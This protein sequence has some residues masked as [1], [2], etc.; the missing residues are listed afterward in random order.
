MH[1]L[2]IHLKKTGQTLEA[3]AARVGSSAPSLSR[4]LNGKQSP[5]LALVGRILAET[6]DALSAN[7]FLPV[8]VVDQPKPAR[9]GA[10]AA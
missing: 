7:D 3:F 2:R 5:S 9:S 10:E 4:I 8:A 1:P 6:G